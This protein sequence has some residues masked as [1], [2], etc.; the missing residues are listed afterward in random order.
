M[1]GLFV[2]AATVSWCFRRSPWAKRAKERRRLE[3]GG[4]AELSV[5]DNYAKMSRGQQKA[6]A[7]QATVN[8]LQNSRVRA[9]TRR[10]GYSCFSCLS[11]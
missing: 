8:L 6:F 10:G 9:C 1:L 7:M 11:G 5:M 4:A 2:V 3:K